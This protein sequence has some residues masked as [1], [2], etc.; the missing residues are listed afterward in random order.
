MTLSITDRYLGQLVTEAF[1]FKFFCKKETCKK[2]GTACEKCD[3]HIV[4]QN[5]RVKGKPAD[6][7]TEWKPVR[8]AHWKKG[9]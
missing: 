4:I 3:E 2:C 5:A 7:N 8:Y 6:T 9:D 1:I